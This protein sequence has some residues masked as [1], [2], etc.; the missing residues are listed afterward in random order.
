MA[1]F[2]AAVACHIADAEKSDRAVPGASPGAGGDWLLA[3]ETGRVGNAAR[4]S[5]MEGWCMLM[6]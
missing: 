2:A 5:V 4:E 1:Q 3:E 6:A